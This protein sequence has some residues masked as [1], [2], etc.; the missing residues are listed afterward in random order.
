[1]WSI[2]EPSSS[3]WFGLLGPEQCTFHILGPGGPLCDIQ[4]GPWELVAN[5]QLN[6]EAKLGVPVAHQRL[7]YGVHELCAEDRIDELPEGEYNLL[8]VQR[9]LEPPTPRS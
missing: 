6:I 4:C 7:F 5:M 3:H 2:N 9:T 8:L 1:M